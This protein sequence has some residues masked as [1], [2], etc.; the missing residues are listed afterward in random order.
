MASSGCEVEIYK[1][2]MRVFSA[3]VE[4]A[5]MT[6]PLLVSVI[7]VL[8]GTRGSSINGRGHKRGGSLEVLF[9]SSV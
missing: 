4:A 9:F 6:D 7:D 1:L 8:V 5:R 2:N 3:L